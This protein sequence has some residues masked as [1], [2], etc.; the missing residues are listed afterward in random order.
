MLDGPPAYQENKKQ[1]S[2]LYRRGVRGEGEVVGEGG[3][4]VGEGVGEGV[5]TV[6]GTHVATCPMIAST[7]GKGRSWESCV[8]TTRPLMSVGPPGG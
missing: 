7:P 8:A 6:G 2:F 1:N 5:G 3:V 4:V